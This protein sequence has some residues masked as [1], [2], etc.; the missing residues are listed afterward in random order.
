MVDFLEYF[1][2]LV[3]CFFVLWFGGGDWYGLCDLIV[4]CDLFGELD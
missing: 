2:V 1:C 3:G 4:C